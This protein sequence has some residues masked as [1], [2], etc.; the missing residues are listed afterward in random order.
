[1]YLAILFQSSRQR[2]FEQLR[3]SLQ[4]LGRIHAEGFV[5]GF[6]HPNGMAVLESAQ[7]FQP[8]GLFQR[9]HRQIGI[10]QQEIAP[11]HVQADVLEMRY[12][13]RPTGCTEWATAKNRWRFQS[14]P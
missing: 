4:I 13:V 10:A 11:I 7:L 2:S 9:P 5:F 8:L 14:G 3:D 1:M 6:D 12:A